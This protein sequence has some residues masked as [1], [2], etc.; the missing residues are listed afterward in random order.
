MHDEISYIGIKSK[1]MNSNI[2]T[3]F[4]EWQYENERVCIFSPHDDDAIIG[5]GYAIEAS[6]RNKAEVYIFI[7]C[8]GNAGY[9][10]VEQ[11]EYITEIRKE[12]TIRAYKNIGI[13]EKNIIWFDYSDFSAVQ[14]IGW[15]LNNG[16]D[17]SFASVIKVLRKLRITRILIPN[18]YREH[19]D[20][21]AV[22]IMGTFYAPQSGDP[23]LIDWGEAPCKVRSV[24]EYSV[25]ADLSPEDSLVEGRKSD[26]RANM[27]IMVD[28]T[29]ENK[30]RSGI[31]QYK[32]Q[33]EIIKGL[34]DS[35]SERICCDNHYIE[36]YLYYDPRPKLNYS[37][38]KKF[39]EG[40]MYKLEEGSGF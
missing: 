23:I 36:V 3:I 6:I 7:F 15:R 22:S 16:E 40:L 14:E 29:I 35:R 24:L 31:L 20:H 5:A 27:I 39:A 1:K 2:D 4:P 30:V 18:H 9:S 25:W 11:K 10:I 19:I 38:Y 32:S 26:M 17:G 8:R 37:P 13:P 21:L 34:V 12:E 28:K 33:G